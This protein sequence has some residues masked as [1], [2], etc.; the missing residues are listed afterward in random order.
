MHIILGLL[1]SIITIL[2]LLNRLAEIGVDLGG[3]NPF[4][5]YRRS[6]WKNRYHGNPIYHIESPLEA[7]AL[8][9][10]AVAKSDGDMSAEEK[11]RILDLFQQEFRLSKKDAS[12]LMIASV[13]LLRDGSELRENVKKVLQGS[14]H[15]FTREQADSALSLINQIVSMERTD[16]P[17][18]EELVRNIAEC[19]QPA[20]REKQKWH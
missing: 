17:I 8:L 12:A 9:L 11:R 10:V 2:V 20:T 5:W 16:N 19:L 13:Y 1:G 18:K 14:L 15:N 3:L 4:L 6:R 7:T